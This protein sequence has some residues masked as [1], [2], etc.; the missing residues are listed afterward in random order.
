MP[1]LRVYAD[2]DAIYAFR[3][4]VVAKHGH[5]HGLLSEEATKAL[6]AHAAKLEAELEEQEGRD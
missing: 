1:K 5:L 4:A 3:R 6:L 2:A